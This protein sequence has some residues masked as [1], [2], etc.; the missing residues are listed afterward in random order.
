MGQ[1]QSSTG[2]PSDVAGVQERDLYKILEVASDA[3]ADE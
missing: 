3:T 1:G 2:A